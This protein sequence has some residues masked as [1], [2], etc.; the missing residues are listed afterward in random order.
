L[1]I[2]TY[3]C[4]SASAAAEVAAKE[5]LARLNGPLTDAVAVSFE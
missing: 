2:I 4:G 3:Y 5:Y 1:F